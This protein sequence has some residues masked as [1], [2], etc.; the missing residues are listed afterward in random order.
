LAFT[1]GVAGVTINPNSLGYQVGDQITIDLGNGRPAL[2][3]VTDAD[4]F[5]TVLEIA[6]LDP[7]SFE[8]IPPGIITLT[9]GT[10]RLS[11]TIIA[12]LSTVTIVNPGSG[13]GQNNTFVNLGGQEY[14]TSLNMADSNYDLCL[15]LGYMTQ[16]GANS[17]D[18]TKTNPYQGQIVQA[19]VLEATIQGIIWAG[20][21]RVDGELATFDEDGTRFVDVDPSTETTFDQN[22]TIWEGDTTTWD[23]TKIYWPAYTQTVFDGNHTLFDY[24]RTLFDAAEPRSTSVYSRSWLWW[25]GKPYEN[26]Y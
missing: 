2:L 7:G 17:F 11:V 9:S 23:L 16:S 13:Y 24:Y 22:Q 19:H 18:L 26:Q 21:T 10:K 3:E 8:R 20:F 14:N 25:F 15:D 5:G 12:G 6:V 4:N 1:V